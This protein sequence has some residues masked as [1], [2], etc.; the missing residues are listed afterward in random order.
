[1]SKTSISWTDMTFNP[2]IG[3]TK[4]SDGCK[5]CYALTQD[6]RHGH[7]SWGPK[8]FRR[9]TS[10]ESYW[11][12]PIKWNEKA[13]LSG[14]RT[15]VFCASMSDVFDDWGGQPIINATGE[16][17][18]SELMVLPDGALWIPGYRM[19]DDARPATLKDVRA[20]LFDMIDRTPHLDWQ[21]LTKR[22]E[23]V[24][25]MVPKH[26]QDEFPPHVWLG[27]SV[28]DQ[29]SANERIPHLLRCPAAVRFL[30]VEPLLGSV[31]LAQYMVARYNPLNANDQAHGRVRLPSGGAGD[32]QDRCTRAHLEGAQEGGTQSG[33][34]SY[35]QV[36]DQQDK[37]PRP[38]QSIS[39]ETP[40]RPDPWLPHDQSQERQQEGQSPVELRIGD[41]PRAGNS[42]DA[43]PGEERTSLETKRGGQPHGA[44]DGATG[45]RGKTTEGRR[46]EPDR[47]RTVDGR[48]VEGSV[49]NLAGCPLGPCDL[50]IV[51]GESGAGHRPMDM[52]HFE[53]VCQQ[54]VGA[55]V[56]L[57]VKQDSGS[58]PGM[59]GRIS[60]K[61]WGYK[62]F[63][64]VGGQ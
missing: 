13:A 41:L 38:G 42:R 12:Q 27:T 9:V 39:M 61:W 5:N 52:A 63:P 1:M 30:S 44:T 23:L 56:P 50:V 21:L 40:A 3:C 7:S 62:Q 2:W 59:Q 33:S 57:F 24:M 58:R 17:K 15:K 8:G 16:F 54:V 45:S 37:A 35:G 28:E 64:E 19:R 31:D 48:S 4:V 14:T 32:F 49:K 46:N 26:W 51:G 29:K 10:L 25:D 60:E 20:R 47:S 11:K 55:G 53:S 18:D 34:V 22:P 6:A 36:D 43:R